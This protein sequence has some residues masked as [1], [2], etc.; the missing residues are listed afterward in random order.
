MN[1]QLIPEPFIEIPAELANDIGVHGGE[2]IKVSSIRGSY[3]AK[4]M[5]TKRIKPLQVSGKQVYPIGIPI[6]WAYRGIREDREREKGNT[7]Y[8]NPINMLSPAAIDPNAYTPEFKGFLVKV[9][10]A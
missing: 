4:A 7:T 2:K 5:V 8:L 10:K 6:H 1:V 3:V 9:E